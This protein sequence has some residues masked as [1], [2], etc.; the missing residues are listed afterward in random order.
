MLLA[1]NGNTR[2]VGVKNLQ[3][4]DILRHAVFLRSSAGRNTANKIKHRQILPTVYTKDGKRISV[5]PSVQGGWR[6]GLFQEA[7]TA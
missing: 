4:T 7:A 6:P 3:D 1:V 5:S 2:V